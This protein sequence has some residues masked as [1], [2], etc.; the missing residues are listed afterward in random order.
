M[1][2]AD[3]LL[4]VDVGTQAT[5]A[6]L[7]DNSGARLGV[8]EKQYR[9]D[10][11]RPLW[12]E[13]WPNV[14]MDAVVSTIRGAIGAAQIAPSRVAGLCV[15]GLY[16]G[17]GIPLD[18]H[19]KPVRPCLI[20]MDR[21]S[22]D[23]VESIARSVDLDELY[24]ITGN[25]VD[26][27]FGYTKI[28]WIRD[29]EPANWSRICVFLAPS[30][31]VVYRLT[32]VV[33]TD[34]S[35]AG[36]LGGIYDLRHRGW[37]ED[38]AELL[39]IPMELMPEHV[40]PSA[41]I[42]GTIHEEGARLTGLPVGTPMLAGG[43]DAPMATLAAGGVAVGDGVA[44]L[45]SSTCW[46]TIHS[47]DQYSPNLVS[48]PHVDQ[49]MDRVYT[50]AGSATSGAIVKWFREEFAGKASLQGITYRQLDAA[51]ANVPAGCDGLVTLPYFMGE[52]APVWD[53]DARGG[54]FGLTLAHTQAH[55]YRSF[56]EAAGFSLR[57]AMEAG[58]GAGLPDVE[59]LTVVGGVTRSTLWL[60]ILADIVAR[61]MRT[62]ATDGIGA[63]LG[64]AFLVARALGWADR[65]DDILRWLEFRDPI[66]PREENLEVYDRGYGAFR[67][68]YEATRG[69]FSDRSRASSD[70]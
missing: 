27:Y 38:A 41:E 63:P 67:R 4:G 39:G 25:W 9:V 70:R 53:P 42:V 14:W 12:A 45:G 1:R 55:V 23:Q 61:P 37:S 47:G 11:P 54:V 52:R 40:V 50:W 10:T 22:T 32:G 15:S 68:L 21:R 44:M 7:V 57:H 43:V 59:I 2:E 60:Q 19:M 66:D 24:R 31:Y 51:A 3:L 69:M 18:R 62:L 36:N 65:P 13:Q 26:S 8:A 29:N 64:G 33:V 6:V 58:R 49:S 35:S 34:H 20:W 48:M 17:S 30:S 28:L 16:G 5:K 46:G 56:L